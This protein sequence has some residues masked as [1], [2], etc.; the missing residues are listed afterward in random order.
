[1]GGF[2]DRLGFAFMNLLR[3]AAYLPDAIG[4]QV[5]AA[6]DAV[7]F[8]QGRVLLDRVTSPFGSL[9]ENPGRPGTA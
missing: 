3:Q 4:E 8:D 5:S 9:P 7:P 2:S 6:V 1:M